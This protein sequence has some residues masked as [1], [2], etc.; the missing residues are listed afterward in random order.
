[1]TLAGYVLGGSG[2]GRPGTARSEAVTD[3]SRPG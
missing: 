3:T 2:V 1:L